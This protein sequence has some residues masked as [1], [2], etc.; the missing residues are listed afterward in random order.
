MD[1]WLITI[2]HDSIHDLVALIS[3]LPVIW[4]LIAHARN[5]LN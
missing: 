2:N 4:M 3:L 5:S 1:L